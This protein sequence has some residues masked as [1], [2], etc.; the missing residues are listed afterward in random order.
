V[1]LIAYAFAHLIETQRYTLNLNMLGIMLTVP[2]NLTVAATLM[3]AGLT[4]A[5]MDWLLRGHPHFEGES[6]FQH[7]ILPALTAF[8]LGVP[9]YNLPFG[10]AWWLSFGL[11]GVLLLLVFLAEYIALDASDVR[12]PVASAGLVALSYALFLILTTT[13]SFSASRLVLIVF[14]VFPA[15]GM[16][17]LRALRLRTREWKFA[18]AIGIAIVLTQLAAALHYWPVTPIQYGLLLLGPLYA[19]T[20]LALNLDEDISPQRAGIEAAIELVVFWAAAFLLRG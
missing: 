16:V 12:H 10:P 18:W 9:L 13:L 19:L 5:G 11:G 20:E 8:V 6:T 14:A 7:W 2:L 3:A 1:V 15:A 4:A 17:A